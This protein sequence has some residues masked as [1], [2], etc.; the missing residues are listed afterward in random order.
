MAFAAA[1]IFALH[2]HALEAGHVPLRATLGG[3]LADGVNGTTPS[4]EQG[5]LT[6]FFESLGGGGWTKSLGWDIVGSDPCG[7][8][9]AWF[10]VTCE[11]TSGGV[12]H[13][14]RL[15]LPQNNARGVLPPLAGLP[16]LKALDLSNPSNDAGAANAVGGTLD[17][18][19]ELGYLQRVKLGY[20]NIIGGLP[21]C[22]SAMLNVTTLD[23]RFN[24]ISGTTPD[25]VCRMARLKV[26]VVRGNALHG[27]IPSCLGGL[28][29]LMEVDY[30]SLNA[31]G[32]YPGP[33]SLEGSIPEALCN[34][35]A[36]TF[37]AL[38]HT[39]GLSG[40]IP[41]CL[42]RGQPLL[43]EVIIQGNALTGPI[44]ESLCEAKNMTTLYL[45]KNSLQS[46][47]PTCLGALTNVVYL[48]LHDNSLTGLIPEALCDLTE[49]TW[50][51]LHANSLH[52]TIPS[53]VGTAFPLLEALFLHDNLLEGS[54]PEAWG[55][56]ALVSIMLSNNA[57]L[58]GTIPSGLFTQRLAAH[59]SPSDSGHLTSNPILRDVVIEGTR[60]YGTVP[61]SLCAAPQ[62]RTL[63]LSGNRLKGS[64]PPCFTTLKALQT[65]RASHN[66]VSGTL[67]G[68]VG[69]LTALTTMDLGYNAI[70]GR[71]PA[72]LGHMAL[73]LAYV[74][75]EQNDLSCEL[76][77]S[78]RHWPQIPPESRI[79]LLQGNLFGCG[80]HAPPTA[81]T[82]HDARGLRHAN[83]TGADA[84]S[85]GGSEYVLP[86]GVAGLVVVALGLIWRLG[87]LRLRWRVGL[88]WRVEPSPLVE[89]FHDACRELTRLGMGVVG[90][91]VMPALVVLGLLAAGVAQSSYECEYGA[92]LTLANKGGGGMTALS[93]GVGAALGVG[94]MFGLAF[95]WRP[96]LTPDRSLET[97]D[98]SGATART[99]RLPSGA[100]GA[101]GSQK[102]TTPPWFSVAQAACLLLGILLLA[103]GP[104]AGYVLV[105]LSDLPHD[106][107]L[108]SAVGI[109]LV[110]M[111]LST[112][113]IPLTT[114]RAVRLLVPGAALS[115]A[116]FRLRVGLGT[117]LSA[118]T[119]IA[120]PVVVV[121]V[122]DKRCLYHTWHQPE[123]VTTNVVIEYC[124]DPKSGTCTAYD[125]EVFRSTFS[126]AFDYDGRR[127][128]SATLSAYAPVFIG[129]VLLTATFP[130]VLELLVV[131][132]VAPWCH[133][134]SA[135]SPAARRTLAVLRGLSWNV[136]PVL[137]QDYALA[138]SQA[139]SVGS[140]GE[141]ATAG[142]PLPPLPPIYVGYL[143][144]RVLER[145]V[146]QLMG[147]LLVALTLGLAAPVVGGACAVAAIV[148]LVHHTHV[149]GTVVACGIAGRHS[150]PCGQFLDLEGCCFVPRGCAV[151]VGAAVLFVWGV[152]SVD[153]LDPAIMAGAAAA[154]GLASA[155]LWV[156]GT[157]LLRARYDAEGTGKWAR[158]GRSGATE[159][160]SAGMSLLDEPLVGSG[161]DEGRG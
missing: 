83:P 106:T 114:R 6:T 79:Y 28:S 72:G 124:V 154:V 136:L 41:G 15:A 59:D 54:L 125:E 12:S 38:Q 42:G 13:V 37:L 138:A 134:K 84:Y 91:S 127:C 121:L 119:T 135:S 148:Q 44:S 67:P 39:Q 137:A 63:A 10:G 22:L 88:T 113:A 131:P 60:L 19:C 152:A 35:T 102:G 98:R 52:G 153:F 27:T 53:C 71:V 58:E 51:F 70:A 31:D 78:V 62:L 11:T 45:H 141:A 68:D 158:R 105:S 14:T 129:S 47:I 116:R 94:L 130:A 20:N 90:A 34:L 8:D 75:L 77:E 61:P 110:K 21:L 36:L 4:E 48:E 103:A 1:A 139:P 97:D 93:A 43:S 49:L 161:D 82:M 142:L 24:A 23:V 109:T 96:V 5:A 76:P 9:P 40:Q 33:Q 104:N 151:V 157:R 149:L 30:S 50:L 95:W 66:H 150:S 7:R 26:F 140:E 16:F 159:T 17:A 156:G 81:L 147:T 57:G 74:S 111:A 133:A 55:L 115:S 89:E 128:V 92:A 144:Q 118:L 25:A 101:I 87:S 160:Y 18:L 107:K 145:G 112:T 122:T 155:L 117:A 73:H 86:T 46:N 3:A 99:L 100:D 2:A 32:G 146:T 123:K 56:P 85:C 64:L 29:A 143:A 126:P 120:A 69:N 80:G 132:L 65:L 108:G